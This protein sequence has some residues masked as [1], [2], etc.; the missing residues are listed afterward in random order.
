MN[1]FEKLTAI[2]RHIVAFQNGAQA[3]QIGMA[4]TDPLVRKSAE[5]IL[6]TAGHAVLTAADGLEAVIHRALSRVLS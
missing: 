1:P 2:M 5:T 6:P 4:E 3:V